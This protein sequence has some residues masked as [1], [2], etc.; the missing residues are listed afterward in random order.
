MREAVDRAEGKNAK[1]N[2]GAKQP[3]CGA[4]DGAVATSRN[5]NIRSRSDGFIQRRLD[6]FR[7]H[8]MDLNLMAGFLE[9]G[10]RLAR[11][12]FD[13]ITRALPALRLMTA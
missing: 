2:L 12:L 4:S 5:K 13:R 10:F 9:G 6:V 3:A 11:E 8:N 7:L 1:R